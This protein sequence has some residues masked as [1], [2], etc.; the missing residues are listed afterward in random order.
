MKPSKEAVERAALAIEDSYSAR[1]EYVG[2]HEFHVETARVALT[3]AMEP[4]ET[5]LHMTFLN[6][7]GL[8]RLEDA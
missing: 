4:F 5:H 8:I 1:G 2:C 7:Y 3:A 6:T